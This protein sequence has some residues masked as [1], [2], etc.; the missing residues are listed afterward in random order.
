[1]ITRTLLEKLYDL[2]EVAVIVQQTFYKNPTSLRSSS[3]CRQKK[4]TSERSNIYRA[5]KT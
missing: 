5:K 2:S 4:Q 1:M 3:I